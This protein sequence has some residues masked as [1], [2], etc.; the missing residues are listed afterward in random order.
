MGP[1]DVRVGE[2]RAVCP[3]VTQGREFIH[4]SRAGGP[5]VM[6][7]GLLFEGGKSC[8]SLSPPGV[9]S[10]QSELWKWRFDHNTAN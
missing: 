3:R 8:G 4:L 7:S 5:R 1:L 6:S 9:Q 2:R 10:G